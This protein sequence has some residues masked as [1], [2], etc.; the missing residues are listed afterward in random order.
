L[1]DW[2][3]S[4][5]FLEDLLHPSILP[6]LRALALNKPESARVYF[7]DPADYKALFSRLDFVQYYSPEGFSIEVPQDLV[8]VLT[9]YSI[10]VRPLEEIVLAYTRH[11]H[12]CNV[13]PYVFSE[14]EYKDEDP[15][16]VLD[17][18]VLATFRTLIKLLPNHPLE[19]LTL[20]RDIFQ[21]NRDDQSTVE[22]VH[23]AIKV[24][25]TVETEV[26]WDDEE[27]EFDFCVRERFWSWVKAK[28]V[29]RRRAVTEDA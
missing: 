11:L 26:L 23:E 13:V 10:D 3:F 5:N 21:R 29:E 12:L 24:C 14:H 9:K 17:H 6:A 25:A 16:D 19:T 15:D 1:I 18:S 27:E 4:P 2:T 22:A 28:K 20:P 7:E 8:P